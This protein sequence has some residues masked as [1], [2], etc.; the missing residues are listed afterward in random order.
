[1]SSAGPAPTASTARAPRARTSAGVRL[2]KS[3]NIT[4]FAI[5]ETYACRATSISAHDTTTTSGAAAA[6]PLAVSPVATPTTS[7]SGCAANSAPRPAHVNGSS[8]H[9]KIRIMT[10]PMSSLASSSD[11]SSTDA[12]AAGL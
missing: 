3:A 5:V 7:K 11:R 9:T 6:T 8:L 12:G 10:S 4:T 1:M 2:L